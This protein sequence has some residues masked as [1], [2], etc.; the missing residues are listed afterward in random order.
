MIFCFDCQMYSIRPGSIRGKLLYCTNLICKSNVS[1]PETQAV[2]LEELYFHLQSISGVKVDA[3]VSDR[4]ELWGR[5]CI[6][7][8]V[9]G[10]GQIFV[11]QV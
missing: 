3:N 9:P 8:E 6:R 5:P 4:P 10:R 11:Q 7:V 2:T 1:E